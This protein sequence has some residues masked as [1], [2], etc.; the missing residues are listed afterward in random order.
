MRDL[1]RLTVIVAGFAAAVQAQV[2]ERPR[3]AG[4]E[5]LVPGGRFM[6]RFEV[7]T[8]IGNGFTTNCWGG[9]NVKPR[10][11]RNGIEDAEY[12]YWGGN[13]VRERGSTFAKATADKTG[14]GERGKGK[15]DRFHLFVAR[16]KES[17]PRGRG[18]ATGS[19]LR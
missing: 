9:E 5:R 10:D 11:V 7:A 12:S 17:E 16:W 14:N 8:P 1:L 13:I 19:R 15:M 3:P 18:L 4:W 2:V 6:D